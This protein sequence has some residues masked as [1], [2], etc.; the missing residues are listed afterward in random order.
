MRKHMPTTRNKL[1]IAFISDKII[2]NRGII[3][4]CKKE[5]QYNVEKYEA[6]FEAIRNKYRDAKRKD[7]KVDLLSLKREIE[8][9]VRNLRVSEEKNESLLAEAQDMLIDLTRIIEESHCQP[10]RLKKV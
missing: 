5:L 9:F 10:F 3:Q 6:H 7:S 8:S 1:S 4:H 2:R